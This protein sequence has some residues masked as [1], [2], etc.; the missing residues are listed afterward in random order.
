LRALR[1]LKEC[2]RIACEDTRHSRKLLSHYDIHK[3]LLSFHAHSGPE[4]AA[5]F[6]A[7]L[8]SGESIA[9][10]SDAGMPGIS[11]PGAELVIA[12]RRAGIE[13]IVIPGA[14][15]LPV[16][17][18]LAGT[19]ENR[20]VFEGFLP[21]G[22]ARKERLVAI[23]QELRPV[24][25]FEGPHKL[26]STLRDLIA[27]GEPT[28]QITCCRELTKIHEQVWVGTLAEALTYFES[29]A[30]RGEFTLVL[31]GATLSIP[32]P[33]NQEQLLLLI[34][35]SLEAGLSRSEACKQLAQQTGL[36]RRELYQLSLQLENSGAYEA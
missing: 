13:V 26:L 9:F 33:P 22:S 6:I 18:A 27:L 5:Q 20:F 10:I 1:I 24:V 23:A 14:S 12:C 11:D 25:L 3:P 34:R 16:A 36:P 4:R 30:P 28:R 21:V 29:T 7:I 32:E 35:Q 2:D 15:A 19:L 8:Q 17:L 31:A